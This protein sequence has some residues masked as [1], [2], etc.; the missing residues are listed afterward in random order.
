MAP[1][2]PNSVEIGGTV[3][4]AARLKWDAAPGAIGY[5]VYYRLTTEPLWERYLW[6]PGG[7]E[8]ELTAEGLVVD[9]YYFG[10][11]AVGP[12]GVESMVVF[13]SVVMVAR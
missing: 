8:T 11:S 7:D 13:P 4:P 2:A 10:V 1:A 5:K 3:E 9:N 12:E 6:V